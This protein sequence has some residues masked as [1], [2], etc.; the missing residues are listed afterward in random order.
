MPLATLVRRI[1][2][3]FSI[4][5]PCGPRLP[6]RLFV[7]HC[8]WRSACGEATA[9]N[10]SRAVDRFGIADVDEFLTVR[11][12]GGTDLVIEWTVIVACNAASAFGPYR[13]AAES[14]RT[15]I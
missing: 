11:R 3:S 9:P 10:V 1:E 14:I 6:C 12:P 5:G 4:G 15:H 7:P 13:V 2:N 8:A